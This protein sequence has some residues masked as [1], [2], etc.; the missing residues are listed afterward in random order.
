LRKGLTAQVL[1]HHDIRKFSRSW[2]WLTAR[3]DVFDTFVRKVH[4]SG[5]D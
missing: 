4:T 1:T 3:I 5:I 2:Q